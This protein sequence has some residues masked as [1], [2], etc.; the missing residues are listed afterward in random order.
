MKD[1]NKSGK[2]A[3]EHAEIKES[4]EPH[5]PLTEEETNE[6]KIKEGYHPSTP[7][8]DNI[9]PLEGYPASKVICS[10]EEYNEDL[11]KRLEE[12][13]PGYKLIKYEDLIDLAPD[14]AIWLK[15]MI[16]YGNVDSQVMI[17]WDLKYDLD[18]DANHFRCI[19]YTNDHKYSI[20]G[21]PPTPKHTRGYLGCGGDSRKPRPGEYWH[22][23]NDLPDGDYSKE[24]FDRIVRGIVAYEIKNLQ[25]WRK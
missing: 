21:H 6:L 8:T 17:W 24:T 19:F 18:P 11:K 7:E 10:N 2:N 1:A 15:S 4:H 9:V 16:R 3:P 14:F 23:G 20:Y 13:K 25:L 12:R 22:R 5:V